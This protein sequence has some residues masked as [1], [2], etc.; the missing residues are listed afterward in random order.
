MAKAE[1]SILICQ[2]FARLNGANAA[3]RVISSRAMVC[4][5]LLVSRKALW[6]LISDLKCRDIRILTC[7]RVKDSELIYL[8]IGLSKRSFIF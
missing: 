8:I 4:D 3:L 2:F 5:H 7:W 1:E 6:A